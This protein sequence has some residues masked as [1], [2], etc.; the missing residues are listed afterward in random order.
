V[1]TLFGQQL[2][3]RHVSLVGT[4]TFLLLGA[5]AGASF[6]CFGHEAWEVLSHRGAVVRAL[7]IAFVVQVAVYHADL[8][9]LRKVGD[10]VELVVRALLVVSATS[11]LLAPVYFWFP[12]LV[13]GR[14]VFLAAAGFVLAVII[15]WRLLFVWLT[16]FVPPRER[17]LLV[18]TGSAAIE[19]ARELYQRRAELG[20][21]IVGFV[22]PDPSKVGLSLINPGIIGT[23]ADIP[24][25]VRRMAVGR[26]VVS[27]ADARG[28]LPMDKLLEMRLEGVAF[29]HLASV[30]E[31][32]TGKIA[33]ENLRPS[34]LIFSGG[35][36]KTWGLLA[37]K[38]AGDL[39]LAS[40]GL[41]LAMP[42]MLLIGLAIRRTSPGPALYHQLRVG[43]HGRVFTLHKF[44]SMRSDAE[45]KTGAVWAAAGNDPRVTPLGRFLRRARLDELPQL[46]NVLVGDMSFVGPRP[47]RPEFVRDLVE[48]IP[49]YGQRHV[50]KPG[51]TGWAQVRYSYGASVEDAVEKLQYDLFYIKNLSLPLDVYVMLETVKT[52]LMRSGS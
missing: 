13:V 48:V 27:L 12:D 8:Y 37:V 36:R 52:V 2:G 33:V 47:E 51:I 14:R 11:I 6:F 46:W 44:R 26:V 20:V 45:M 1:T 40:L 7:L 35:F 30:Y 4:E 49:F 3:M 29:D 24:D 31:E 41:A 19:L 10:R 23:I 25:I 39:A 32:Y 34:W 5:V 21:E 16:G 17:L 42:L 38:R 9:D 28:R 18:G 43:Q 15:G 50:V 22:D